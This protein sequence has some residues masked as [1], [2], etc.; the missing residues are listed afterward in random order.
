MI[1]RLDGQRRA[2]VSGAIPGE[3][4]Q[5]AD[6]ARRRRAWPTPMP[7]RSRSRRRI[8]ALPFGDPLCGGCLYSHIAY[9]RQLDDQEPGDRRR[10]HAHR[11]AWSCRRRLP[12]PARR[13]TATGCARGCTCAARGSGSFARA[14]TICAT[15]A[16]RGSC[17]PRRCDALDRLMAAMR[18]IGARHGARDRAVGERRRQRAGRAP[19]HLRA[20]RSRAWSTKLDVGRRA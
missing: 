8:A 11:R 4:V 2:R 9:P 15:R 6:R 16:P 14:R 3:R 18:S 17:C 10:L 5:R 1:A 20:A 13:K 7:S 12:S 19:R